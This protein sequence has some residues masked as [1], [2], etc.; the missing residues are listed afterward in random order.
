M[1]ASGGVV[2]QQALPLKSRVFSTV[3][4]RLRW[5][6]A[7]LRNPRLRKEPYIRMDRSL[8]I[9]LTRDASIRVG[10]GVHFRGGGHI[11][12]QGR[13]VIG[14]DVFFNSG[15]VISVYEYVRI[16]SHVRIGER[17]SIHDENHRYGADQIALNEWS[18]YRT[19]PVSI[20]DGTW[21]GANVVVLAGAQIGA[22]CVV[23]AG[24][25]VSGAFPAHSLIAGAPARIVRSLSE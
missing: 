9:D 20:G 10:Q 8:P 2:Q 11:F 19:R 22:R 25:V 1:N 3:K 5:R 17:V 7:V 16:G 6:F 12:C 18:S 14:D 21:I 4:A 15:S 13:L 23:A 24:S